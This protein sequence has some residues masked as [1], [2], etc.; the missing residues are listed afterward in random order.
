MS[1]KPPSAVRIARMSSARPS[2]LRPVDKSPIGEG[3]QWVR[4]RFAAIV[5]GSALRAR[6]PV[7]N[8]ALPGG[9]ARGAL[10]RWGLQ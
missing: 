3:L 5:V 8:G 6:A 10:K 4:G 9:M 7:R 2:V 1:G